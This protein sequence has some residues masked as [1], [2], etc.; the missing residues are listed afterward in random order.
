MSDQKDKKLVQDPEQAFVEATKK[1]MDEMVKRTTGK[2]NEA[3]NE[4]ILTGSGKIKLDWDPAAVDSKDDTKWNV[5]PIYKVPKDAQISPT[6]S[7]HIQMSTD[8]DGWT[9]WISYGDYGHSLPPV[10]E[11]APQPKCE[12]GMAVAMGKDDQPSYHSDYCPI[13]KTEVK[14]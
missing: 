9:P 13:K 5:N 7:G 4:A 6:R 3:V 2:F 12:C 11:P 8:Y 14:K 1:I 10:P